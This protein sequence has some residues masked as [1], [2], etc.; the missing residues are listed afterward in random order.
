VRHDA[1]AARVDRVQFLFAEVADADLDD[2][3]DGGHVAQD[4]VHDRG[5]APA[6]PFVGDAQVGVRID[7]Q[8]AEPRMARGDRGDRA[9]RHRVVAAD[10]ARDLA[11][12]EDAFDGLAHDGVDERPRLVDGA[13]RRRV[14]VA[15]ALFDRPR[16]E[17]ARARVRLGDPALGGQQ[18]DAAL[19]GAAALQVVEVDL[20][21]RGEDRCGPVLGAGA[22][23]DGRGERHRHEHDRG[24]GGGV[25][26]AEDAA[27]GSCGGIRVEGACIGGHAASP[28]A[29]T[30]S[31]ATLTGDPSRGSLRSGE[32]RLP[33][34][35]CSSKDRQEEPSSQE[36]GE[37]SQGAHL[38]SL[39]VHATRTTIYAPRPAKLQGA[40]KRPWRA[41]KW[42]G[43]RAR[44]IG[45]TA[46]GKAG[47]VTAERPVDP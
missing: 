11:A 10:D 9:E 4:V 42:L 36:G 7:V 24:V 39:R 21:A 34:W 46:I 28:T 2:A 1:A 16:R 20:T 45:T 31:N 22:V 41:A 19:V 5:V 37:S 43:A 26:Q 29:A 15:A 12:V 47:S 8:D 38:V 18:V 6:E 17:R 3:C 35:G 30:L 14:A 40:A 23:G 13:R 33:G 27:A 25:R 32:K 44:R